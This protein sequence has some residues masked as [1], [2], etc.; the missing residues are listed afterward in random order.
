MIKFSLKVLIVG[1]DWDKINRAIVSKI[2][3]I[4]MVKVKVKY[5]NFFFKF[6]LRLEWEVRGFVWE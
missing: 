4:L 2:S 3:L 5:L 1:I 6:F